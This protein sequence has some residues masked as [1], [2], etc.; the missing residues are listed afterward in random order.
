MVSAAKLF[1]RGSSLDLF[2]MTLPETDFLKGRVMK[3]KR[4]KSR[5]MEVKLSRQKTED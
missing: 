2:P 5:V 1:W 3:V 4:L